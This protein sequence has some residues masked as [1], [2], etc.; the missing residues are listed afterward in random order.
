MQNMQAKLTDRSICVTLR[1][2]CWNVI[3]FT[4]S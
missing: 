1:G 4:K 3:S 2:L